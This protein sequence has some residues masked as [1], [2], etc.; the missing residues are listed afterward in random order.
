MVLR[1]LL[2]IKPAVR[3]FSMQSS[4]AVYST[5]LAEDE[6]PPTMTGLQPSPELEKDAL[7]L[8]PLPERTYGTFSEQLSSIAKELQRNLSTVLPGKVSPHMFNYLQVYSQGDFVN[9]RMAATTTK[10]AENEVQVQVLDYYTSPMVELALRKCG[11]KLEIRR[12]FDVMAVKVLEYDKDAALKQVDD[13]AKIA[14]EKVRAVFAQQQTHAQTYGL[15]LNPQA[16]EVYLAM[17][18]QTVA[19]KKSTL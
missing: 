15:E 12:D 10:V 13:F 18:K 16:E 9:F 7:P 14:K 4:S 17:L 1:A 8:D 2:R 6:V 3:A 11:M 5:E 19:E